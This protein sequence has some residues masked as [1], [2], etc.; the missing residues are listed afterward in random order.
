M[1]KI[2][3]DINEIEGIFHICFSLSS[4][5]QDYLLKIRGLSLI[6]GL[7]SDRNL[8]FLRNRVGPDQGYVEY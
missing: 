1:Y 4:T 8:E 6:R 2:N 3:R 5:R 7:E